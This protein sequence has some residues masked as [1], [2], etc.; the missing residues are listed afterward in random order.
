MQPEREVSVEDTEP[1]T[2]W[3]GLPFDRG[4]GKGGK[5]YYEIRTLASA[6]ETSMKELGA[7]LTKD[8]PAAMIRRHL[9]ALLSPEE[10]TRVTL[11][12]VEGRTVILTLARRSDKF[13]Y[14]RSLVPKL[15]ARLA[16]ELGAMMIRLEV[17]P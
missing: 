3:Q 16:P 8:D 6:V 15:K 1:L 7:T 17:R 4:L 14:N 11:R 5:G 12:K 2:S 9:E 10:Q 13:T